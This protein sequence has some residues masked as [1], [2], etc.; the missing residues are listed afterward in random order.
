MCVFYGC[1]RNY[2][3]EPYSK[4]V[5]FPKDEATRQA[6][7][8]AMP[9]DPETLKDRKD[10]YICAAHFEGKWI[11]VK[12]GKYPANPPSIFPGIPKSCFIQ[13]HSSPRQAITSEVRA[14][15]VK[16]LQDD[17]DKIE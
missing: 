10:I 11:S 14:K 7:I 13:S 6:W 16:Q 8:D 5:K 17:S 2:K 1:R 9:N 3:G 4:V 15:R 12:G